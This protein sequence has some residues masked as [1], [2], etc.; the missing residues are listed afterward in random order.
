MLLDESEFMEIKETFVAQVITRLRELARA[1]AELL[2]R[3]HQHHPHSPLPEMSVQISKIMS[4]VA[5]SLIANWDNLSKEQKQE[6]KRLVIETFPTNFSSAVL[7]NRF[8]LQCLRRI[9]NG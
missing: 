9:Y 8:G 7:A 5:D 3:L 2:A 1:E 4:R 6:L